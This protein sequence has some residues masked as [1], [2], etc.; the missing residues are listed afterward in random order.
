MPSLVLLVGLPGSG[1]S[2]YRSKIVDK[3][4]NPVIASS[5][6]IIDDLCEKAGITYSEGFHQF[7]KT[8]N[9]IFRNDVEDAIKNGNDLIIDRTNMTEKSR[10]PF[11]EM[12]QKS[13]YNEIIAYVFVVPDSELRRRLNSRA[14]EIGKNIPNDVLK[15]MTNSYTAPSKQEGFTKIYFIRD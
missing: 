1:K 14:E 15:R 12:A 6:D 4:N 11:I 3:L 2:T 10:K 7:I 8:A 13:G 9:K 5:D